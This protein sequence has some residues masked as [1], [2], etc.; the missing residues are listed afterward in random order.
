MKTF[1]NIFRLLASTTLSAPNV[2]T[3][4]NGK[5]YRRSFYPLSQYTKGKHR[6]IILLSIEN[7][8]K[9]KM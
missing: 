7:R 6:E 2:I 8:L 3:H 1:P 5:K 4:E 9:E